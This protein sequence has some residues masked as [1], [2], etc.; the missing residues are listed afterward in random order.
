M[1][2]VKTAKDLHNM[3]LLTPVLAHPCHVFAQVAENNSNKTQNLS[4][5]S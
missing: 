3:H 5:K 4:Q 1:V 2:H